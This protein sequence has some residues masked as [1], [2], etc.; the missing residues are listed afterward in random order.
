MVVLR[1]DK[2]VP[3]GPAAPVS[4]VV[5]SEGGLLTLYCGRDWLPEPGSTAPIA[6][7]F[8]GEPVLVIS[9]TTRVATERARR[10]LR[11][12]WKLADVIASGRLGE[13][14]TATMRAALDRM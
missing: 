5:A 8:L 12:A 6:E 3:G 7:R 4:G 2:P 1:V 13:A 10:R 14:A 11:Q 9:G